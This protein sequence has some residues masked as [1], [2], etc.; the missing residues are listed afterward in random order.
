MLLVH[1]LARAFMLPSLLWQL[2][3][4]CQSACVNKASGGEGRRQ[5]IHRVGLDPAGGQPS[6]TPKLSEI[7]SCN[8]LPHHEYLNNV[9]DPLKTDLLEILRGHTQKHLTQK[10]VFLKPRCSLQR[11]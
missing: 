11:K 10:T 9:N 4:W 5:L 2:V 6:P 1:W 3:A 7:S 8:P